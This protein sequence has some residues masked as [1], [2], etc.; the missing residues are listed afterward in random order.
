MTQSSG[1][2][3]PSLW[4]SLTHDHR[5]RPIDP[6]TGDGYCVLGCNGAGW[7]SEDHAKHYRR[8]GRNA[9][10]ER[11]MKTGLALWPAIA[12]LV[13]GVGATA[14]PAGGP[15]TSGSPSSGSA[16]GNPPAGADTLK[17]TLN[18]CIDRALLVGEDMARAQAQRQTAHA[19]YLQARSTALPQLSLSTTYTR[20]IESVFQGQENISPFK[21]DTTAHDTTMADL[22]RRIR[23]LE[24]ALPYSGFY[25]VSELLSSSSFAS[26][27]S[28]IAAL[29][30]RQKVFQGGSIW[31]SVEAAN[32]GLDAAR[33]LED[34]TRSDVILRVRQAYLD[35]LLAQRGVTIAELGRDQADNH[36]TQVRLRQDAGQASE[37]ELLQA[38]VEADNQVPIVRN[39]YTAQE[40]ADLELRRICKLP[41]AGTLLLT[42]PLLDSEAIPAEPTDVDTT[43]LV[44]NAMH[45]SGV[46]AL[47]QA[48]AA[49]GH[50]VTVAAAGKY[51]ELDLFFDG[52]EQAYPMDV[53]PKRGDWLRNADAGVAVT[54]HLFDGLQTKGAIQEAKANQTQSLED[55]T[56]ARSQVRQAVILGRYELEKSAADL[57]ARSRT[58]ELAQRALDLANLRYQEGASSM[59]EVSDARIAWQMAQTNEAQARRDYFA[60]LAR[61]ERYTGQPLFESHAPAMR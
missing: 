43:G 38:E 35:A 28:W 54:W 6:R 2:T 42:T 27:N 33:L 15:T 56:Q 20:Q 46:E 44:E 60:A 16:P 10:P 17:L 24:G 59:L 12:V 22:L 3:V 18:A 21:P 57:K 37:F 45:T 26:Q 51:P 53:F 32:H 1:I 40:A 50:A 13:L 52:G 5:F 30:L 47:E 61:L 9:G 25:A 41:A 58:V 39:A 11:K 4:V 14:A 34:D 48:Y 23:A 8:R 49:R 29:S 36:L 31:A 55:L 7:G 19:R